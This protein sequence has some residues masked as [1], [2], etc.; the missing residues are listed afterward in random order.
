VRQLDYHDDSFAYETIDPP[1]WMFL[2]LLKAAGETNK[3]RTQPIGGEVRPEVQG[4]MWDPSQTN[5][6]SAGQEFSN[7]VVL[8]HAS[9]MLNHGA[10]APGFTGSQKQLA[11]A[12]SASMGYEL[13][14]TNATL[15]DAG[16]SDALGA[17]LQVWNTGVAPFYYNWPVQIG[18]L[19]SS[20][21]LVKTWT[22]SWQLSAVLPSGPNTV[23]TWTQTN[24][25]LSVGS[26]KLLLSVQ[27]PLPNGVRFHF[28]NVAQ[29][30][31]LPG[32]LTL[33]QVS[34]TASKPSLS[35]SVSPNGFDL[36]V[37]NAAPGAWTVE[38]TSNL[39]SWTPL[40]STN[41]TTSQWSVTDPISSS[42][43]FYRVVGTQ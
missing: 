1:S 11:L 2:G 18:A 43:R 23:W 16:V 28:A 6:V 15:V 40:L 8:T 31:D 30:A 7:C 25:G 13:Y 36:D 33:G 10:F 24:H 42:A 41:T 22:T 38:N 32:W 4:C 5:C 27:N 9:W 29:D 26:Y 37:N 39:Y 14:V 19:D 21:H 35:G 17:S 12:G 3:W 20:N 34:I